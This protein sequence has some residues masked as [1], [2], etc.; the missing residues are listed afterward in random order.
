[1]SFNLVVSFLFTTRFPS[2]GGKPGSRGSKDSGREADRV[3]GLEAVRGEPLLDLDLELGVASD[4]NLAGTAT[5]PL[6]RHDGA[7]LKDLASP[8]TPGLVPLDRTGEAL[9][10]QRA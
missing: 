5:R 8:D 4:V 2:L 3:A 9:D 10:A 7:T 1:M 6:A